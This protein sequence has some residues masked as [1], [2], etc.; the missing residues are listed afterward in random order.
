[1]G[2][3]GE[4]AREGVL[5]GF[6]TVIIVGLTFT[7][8]TGVALKEAVHTGPIFPCFSQEERMPERAVV[9]AAA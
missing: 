8:L 5:S 2:Q 4:S 7:V 6:A 1:M 3:D 9:N